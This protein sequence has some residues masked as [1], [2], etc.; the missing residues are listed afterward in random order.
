MEPETI[1]MF[2]NASPRW[3]IALQKAIYSHPRYSKK[4]FLLNIL[5]Y[6][7]ENT[8]KI[9]RYELI[10][11]AKCIYFQFAKDGENIVKSSFNNLSQWEFLKLKHQAKHSC[12]RI[13]ITDLSLIHFVIDNYYQQKKEGAFFDTTISNTNMVTNYIDSTSKFMFFN[14]SSFCCNYNSY[15]IYHS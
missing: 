12:P 13:D 7:Q 15:T 6:S 1:A 4:T 14:R 10:A 5:V 11:L 8:R 2:A 9:N 3:T